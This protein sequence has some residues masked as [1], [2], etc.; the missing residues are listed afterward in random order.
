MSAAAFQVAVKELADA[1]PGVTATR[2]LSCECALVVGAGAG[3]DGGARSCGGC[4]IA[5]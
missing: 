4:C 1:M 2:Y 3:A 5:L